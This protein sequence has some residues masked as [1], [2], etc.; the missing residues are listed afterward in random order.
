M[1]NSSEEKGKSEENVD[2]NNRDLKSS[3][4]DI[5]QGSVDSPF[6][7][8]GELVS[9]LMTSVCFPTTNLQRTAKDNSTA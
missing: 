9:S 8:G 2:E 6:L 5:Y 4:G 7:V 3:F 1:I